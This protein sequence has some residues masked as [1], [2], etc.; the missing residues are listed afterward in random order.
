MKLCGGRLSPFYERIILQ[1]KLKDLENQVE[2]PGIPG[3]DRQS[4]E[5]LA[6]NPL[7]KIPVLIDGDFTLPESGVIAEY[8]EEKFPE[9]SLLPG[10]AAARANARLIAQLGDTY[11]INP[12]FIAFGQLQADAPNQG[13]LDLQTTEIKKGLVAIEH[14]AAGG[15]WMV[16]DGWTLADCALMPIFFFLDRFSAPLGIDPYE[17]RSK[18]RAWRDATLAS[19]LGKESEATMQVALDEFMAARAG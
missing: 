1:L 3:D 10:D 4:E 5:F 19:D 7:G 16:G 12:L 13:I 6:L 18:L 17:G 2:Q 11:L 9:P 14:F 8:L 15:S